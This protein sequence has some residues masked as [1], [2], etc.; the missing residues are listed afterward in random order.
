MVNTSLLAKAL[1]RLLWVT[2]K[3]LEVLI[4]G[5]IFVFILDFIGRIGN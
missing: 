2:G 3:S 4:I 5:L 1:Y